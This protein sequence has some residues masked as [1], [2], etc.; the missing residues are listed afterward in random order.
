MQLTKW[1]HNAVL[2]TI[3][4][5]RGRNA[6]KL[7]GY[8]TDSFRYLRQHVSALERNHGVQSIAVTSAK[9]QEGKTFCTKNLAISLA[10]SGKKVIV[11]DADMHHPKLADEFNVPN[12]LGLSDYLNNPAEHVIQR[13]EYDGLDIISS[14]TQVD[15]SS[16]LLTT[17]Q[18]QTLIGHLKHTYDI[19]L[20]D[21]PPVGLISDY[22]SIGE[23]VDYTIVVVRHGFTSK[24]EV[25]RL[26]KILSDNDIRAGIVYNASKVQD[27]LMSYNGYLKKL[28]N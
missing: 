2:E 26:N 8:L 21:T 24:S 3:P 20:F 27:N 15:N 7:E 22:L 10:K 11:I 9:S 16:D 19:V 14:G 13:T 17:N 12:R 25:E 18:I 1:S 23:S 4:L 5:I 6:E 28:K